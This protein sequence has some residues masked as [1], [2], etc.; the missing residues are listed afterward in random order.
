[1]EDSLERFWKGDTNWINNCFVLLVSV[2]FSI[3][4]PIKSR[5]IEGGL[6][7]KSFTQVVRS[8][9]SKGSTARRCAF[10]R[11]RLSSVDGSD[12]RES[13]NPAYCPKAEGCRFSVAKA[14]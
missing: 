9:D 3:N 6:K 5:L 14:N 13:E 10:L 11:F 12:V 2:R 8:K 4:R 1:M 7:Y